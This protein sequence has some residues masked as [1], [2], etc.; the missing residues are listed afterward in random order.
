[1]LQKMI[2]RM[3]THEMF[4]LERFNE[5]RSMEIIPICGSSQAFQA[6]FR[7]V[8]PTKTTDCMNLM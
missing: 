3:Q 6:P 4:S 5:Y 8:P 7:D 2:A 1:M